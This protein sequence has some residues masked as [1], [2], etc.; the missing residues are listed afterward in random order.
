MRISGWIAGIPKTRIRQYYDLKHISGRNRITEEE[1]MKCSQLYNACF[2]IV[3]LIC[4]PVIYGPFKD[5]DTCDN[6]YS[7]M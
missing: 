3:C 1:E 7:V 6:V 5:G 2:N 4:S